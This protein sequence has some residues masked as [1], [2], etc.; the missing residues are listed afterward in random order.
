MPASAVPPHGCL[1]II[2][3]VT[4]LLA[5]MLAALLYSFLTITL[6]ANQNVTGLALTIFG[7]G[8][9][10][11]VGEDIGKCRRWLRGGESEY[12]GCL[13]RQP[14]FLQE[15]PV[16]GR[17][18]FSYNYLVYLGIGPAVV[19]WAWYLN[20]SRSGLYL[21]SVGETPGTADA[22][23]INVT[24][25]KYLSTCVG[26][27][28][29]GLGGMYVVMAQQQ[30]GAFTTARERQGLDRGGAGHL[31]H[32]ESLPGPHWQSGVRWT[33]GAA[34]LHRLGRGPSGPRSTTSCPM[35]PRCWC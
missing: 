20:R 14:A 32:L 31:R 1:A 26:G 22:A 23:G 15:L 4:S 21:R 3:M 34:A 24:R 8:F 16:V 9:G 13:Y 27:G 30:G 29:C 25:Y 6:R 19:P 10:N 7:T 33:V 2:A 5:G 35:R 12:E 17:L 11:L 18:L 28:I